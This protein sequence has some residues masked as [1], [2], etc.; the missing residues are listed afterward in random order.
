MAGDLEQVGTVDA[1]GGDFYDDLLGAGLGI[2]HGVGDQLPVGDGHG[3]HE[4]HP[5]T[6]SSALT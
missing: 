1:G 2:G 4:G 5:K 3:K 6:I